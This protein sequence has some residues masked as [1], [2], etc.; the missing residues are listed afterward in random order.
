MRWPRIP[1]QLQTWRPS[2]TLLTRKIQSPLHKF[3]PLR[4]RGC[5]KCEMWAPKWS[6]LTIRKYLQ[7]WNIYLSS[8]WHLWKSHPEP[9]WTG[10]CRGTDPRPDSR[11]CV[12][13]LYKDLD[14][15]S[16]ISSTDLLKES[17]F[18]RFTAGVSWRSQDSLSFYPQSSGR[19]LYYKAQ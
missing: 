18:Y 9:P 3:L 6:V 1:S 2:Q 17:L 12:E 8:S 4:K 13:P 16:S 15:W 19:R 5:W 14:G 7:M 11:L 10:T